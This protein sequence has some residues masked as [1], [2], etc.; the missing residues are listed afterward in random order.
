MKKCKHKHFAVLLALLSSF[1]FLLRGTSSSVHRNASACAVLFCLFDFVPNFPARLVNFLFSILMHLAHVSQICILPLP[2][3]ISQSQS[4]RMSSFAT[5][6]TPIQSKEEPQDQTPSE[7]PSPASSSPSAS[8]DPFP[9]EASPP[10]PP[11]HVDAAAP[12]PPPLALE[13][14]VPLVDAP[15]PMLEGVPIGPDGQP[16]DLLALQQLL[17]NPQVQAQL[18]AEAVQLQAAAAANSAPLPPPETPPV[19]MIADPNASGVN[20]PVAVPLPTPEE[21][22]AQ[23]AA[24]TAA[25]GSFL[26]ALIRLI[27]FVFSCFCQFQFCRSLFPV[28]LFF[29]RW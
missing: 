8:A 29:F 13:N 6:E 26:S 5:L 22:A 3:T 28:Y 11:P 1:F 19:A 21:A 17:A 15:P 2:C 4:S 12:L 9:P 14:A 16:L 20:A 18:Q 27:L 23:A 24:A 10:P 7:S 25:A